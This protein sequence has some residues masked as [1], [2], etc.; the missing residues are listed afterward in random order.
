MAQPG[1]AGPG[2]R[3]RAQMV[4]VAL[5]VSL[6]TCLHY[7][8]GFL[9]PVPVPG[10]RLGLA[11]LVTTVTLY[12]LGRLPAL[13]VAALRSLLGSLLGG[14]FLGLGFAMSLAGAT[15]SALAMGL[16]GRCRSTSPVLAST[17]GGLVHNLTQ[18]TIAYLVIGAGILPYLPH[19][20][21]LGLLAGW[22]TGHLARPIIVA[23]TSPTVGRTT[24]A[25]ADAGRRAHV[26]RTGQPPTL[27]RAGS[28]RLV[29]AGALLLAVGAAWVAGYALA[30]DHRDLV[31][32]LGNQEVA[33]IPLDRDAPPRYLQVELPGAGGYRATIE[34]RAGAARILPIPERFCPRGICSHTGWVSRPGQAAI[35]LPNRLVI[36][37][38][39]RP[40]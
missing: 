35:C 17:V 14:K 11:N 3:A 25:G 32:E 2:G 30:G 20:V 13:A 28:W 22:I 16:L 10:A 12:A 19:L 31:V 24:L 15:V 39:D 38:V 21:T 23:L 18:V 5:L 4:Q 27:A 29:A 7:L 1:R 37:V 9:P 6:A 26:A 36:R 40:R 33:R 34:I 8:E